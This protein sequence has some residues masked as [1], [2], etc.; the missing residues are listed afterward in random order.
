MIA[1]WVEPTAFDHYGNILNPLNVPT[2]SPGATL[3]LGEHDVIYAYTDGRRTASCSVRV[4]VG[5]SEL[6]F[7]FSL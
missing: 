5:E 6:I 7:F 2:V 3:N 4:I 1:E